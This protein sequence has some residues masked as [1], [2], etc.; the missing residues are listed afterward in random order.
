MAI[1]AILFDAGD[2]LYSKP[3]RGPA[4]AR[5][6]TERGHQAP[7]A[8]DPVVQEMRLKAYASQIGVQEFMTWLLAHYGVTKTDEIDEGI[9]LLHA[10]QSDV[11]FFDGVPDT[12]HQLKRQGFKLGIVTNTFNPPA[13]KMEWFKTVG[14]ENVWDAYADSCELGVVKPDPKIY[15]HTCELLRVLPEHAVFLDDIGRNLKT[16]RALGMA[17]IKVDEPEDALRELQGLLGFAL[18]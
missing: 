18:L 16:A 13:E 10:Q 4:I 7:V 5:F 15:T 17:T 14:I 3:R 6:L 8:K 2:V 1:S 12:L 9:E 11:T